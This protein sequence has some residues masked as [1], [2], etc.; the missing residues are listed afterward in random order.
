MK[1]K[2]NKPNRGFTIIEVM[3]V[4]AI[5]GLI[6]AIVFIAVPQLQRNTR[7]NQRQNVAS[8]LKAELETYA[9]NNQG[10]YPFSAAVSGSGTLADFQTRYY[11]TIE[12][13]NPS[14]GNDY[15]VSFAA[16]DA[17]NPTADQILI[18]RA[19]SCNGENAT[20]TGASTTTNKYAV[21]MALDRNNTYYCLDNG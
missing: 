10:K 1:T 3:I 17:A 5:A 16:N 7:D 15:S 18:H 4:L 9:S 19:A 8:R 12:K 21:R 20:G 14:T 11:T 6:L 13:K 2:L